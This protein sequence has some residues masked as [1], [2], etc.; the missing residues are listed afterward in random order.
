MYGS[1]SAIIKPRLGASLW[2]VVG[3]TIKGVAMHGV[4]G[5]IVTAAFK[6]LAKYF[7]DIDRLKQE[8]LPL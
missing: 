6:V 1:V 2:L 8:V 7:D 3:G 5:R 4:D